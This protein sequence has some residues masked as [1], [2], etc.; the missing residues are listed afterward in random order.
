[1][2]E[3]TTITIRISQETKAALDRLAQLTKRSRSFLASEAL[4]QYLHDE[5][6]I[7]EGIQRG[8]E[9]ADAGRVTPHEEVMA[10]L[11]EI[12]SNASKRQQKKSA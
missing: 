8:I 9:D 6:E 3:T 11:R 5:V 4:A 12:I 7:A 1:M 2:A 10:E